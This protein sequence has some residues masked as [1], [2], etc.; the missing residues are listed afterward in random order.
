MDHRVVP[1][2]ASSHMKKSQGDRV[3]N[4]EIIATVAG[5]IY[6]ASIES[7]KWP[8][9]LKHLTAAFGAKAALL[10]RQELTSGRVS[11][12]ASAGLDDQYASM[13]CD[14]YTS[15]SANHLVERISRLPVGTPVTRRQLMSDEKYVRREAY[16]RVF[17][18]Q[19]VALSVSVCVLKTS[20]DEAIILSLFHQRLAHDFDG[21]ELGLL[22]SLVPHLQCGLRIQ[23]R[24]AEVRFECVAAEHALDRLPIGVV[25]VGAEGHP[26]F[27]N[28]AAEEMVRGEDGL[29]VRHGR[30][31]ATSNS[32]NSELRRLI[33]ES[34]CG[35]ARSAASPGR[36]MH[37]RG[38]FRDLSV[39]VAP[40]W[41]QPK[42]LALSEHR[43][44][45]MVFVSEPRKQ[46]QVS[47]EV[48]ME[49]YGLTKTEARLA[50]ELARGTGVDAAAATLEM[51]V[52]TA[53]THLKQIFQKTDTHRQAEL[54]R[55]LLLSCAA[56][57]HQTPSPGA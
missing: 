10:R 40:V 49:V 24:L 50:C 22:S 12:R 56:V 44:A 19:E 54:V 41:P 43:P 26:L 18:P 38:S 2:G 47:V 36:A 42:C 15:S 14:R 5:R 46:S 48:L 23:E 16:I 6:E 25:L 28:Q 8:D 9:A 51:G 35:A 1:A 29:S 3:T 34:A 21:H 33:E 55:L 45:A 20:N 7:D 32:G 30:L 39:L 53:R 31:S 27:M 11:W 13:F 37:L 4:G 52:G 17:R 57:A